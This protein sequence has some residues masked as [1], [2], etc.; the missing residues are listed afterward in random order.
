MDNQN[1][2]LTLTHALGE[3]IAVAARANARPLWTYVYGGKPKP[4]F[5][6]VCTPAGHCLTLFE[7]HDHFWH[8]GLWFTIKFLNGENFWE[9]HAPFGTQQTV[10]PPAISHPARGQ[11]RLT[12]ELAWVRPDTTPAPEA[13]FREQRQITFVPLEAD[14]YALDFETKLVAQT[15]LLLDRTPYTTW[16]GYGGLVFR[17]TRNWQESRL[18]FSDGSTS[19][20]PLGYR[21]L[22][23]DL[24]GKLDGG[25][26]LTGGIALFDHPD[27]LRHPSPWYGSTGPNH[28]FN[29]AFL[30]HEPMSV[31]CGEALTFHYRALIHDGMWDVERLQAAYAAY[32]G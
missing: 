31:S 23:C 21:A 16:G 25:R 9:E 20:R 30:F 3:S 17:G 28:Y 22:W 18:L 27:N 5:H 6:P 12:S 1:Q 14:A 10:A 19:T 24:A 2:P 29:A 32:I 15:D 7:P 26:D 4:Y 11:I 8:R 13:V